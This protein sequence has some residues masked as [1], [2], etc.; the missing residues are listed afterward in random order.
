MG[1]PLVSGGYDIIRCVDWVTLLGVLAGATVG[2]AGTLG[3][4]LIALRAQRE[5]DRV[6]AQERARIELRTAITDLISATQRAE[7]ATDSDDYER[8][9]AASVEMWIAY[10]C[11][12]VTADQELLTLAEAY[13]N[14]LNECL[15]RP[16]EEP[17]W[18]RVREVQFPFLDAAKA[19]SREGDGR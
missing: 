6:A 18:Q 17:A 15:W 10:K 7:A 4:Q 1:V 9:S 14:C 19:V 8:R 11:L 12:H 13:C 16:T 5:R 3:A 2:I